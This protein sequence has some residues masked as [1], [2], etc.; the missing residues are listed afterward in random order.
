MA[1][2]MRSLSL[3]V[4]WAIF[5]VLV[6]I[7]EVWKA[8]LGA[9]K[10]ISAGFCGHHGLAGGHLVDLGGHLV[11]TRAAVGLDVYVCMYVC[12]C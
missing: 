5:G 4:G 11:A 9:W 8:I 1:R 7:L 6:G 10:A 12:G 3:R 2:E